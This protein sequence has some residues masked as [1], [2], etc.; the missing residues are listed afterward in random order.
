MKLNRKIKVRRQL[1]RQKP[2]HSYWGLGSRLLP[3]QPT[4]RYY[5]KLLAEM[6]TA[7]REPLSVEDLP[8]KLRAAVRADNAR[9]AVEF[10][11][12]AERLGEGIAEG[13]VDHLHVAL[14]LPKRTRH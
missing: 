1:Y 3:G 13:V 4:R 10:G 6:A 9:R 12:V 14:G 5:E 8:P 2:P 7:D 11:K